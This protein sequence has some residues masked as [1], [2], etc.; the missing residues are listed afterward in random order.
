M[1]T[2]Q[3]YCYLPNG[4][5]MKVDSPCF[6]NADVSSCCGQDWTCL[7]NGLCYHSDLKVL[8]RG[9]CTDPNWDSSDCPQYC[10][11]SSYGFDSFLPWFLSMLWNMLTMVFLKQTNT[12]VQVQVILD[13]MARLY[14]IALINGL[15][16][17][18]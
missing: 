16:K 15:P 13:E 18:G 8:A 17:E 11:E 10:T 6:S 3:G 1:A 2:G 9:T 14:G 4:D 5:L 12:K 7:A